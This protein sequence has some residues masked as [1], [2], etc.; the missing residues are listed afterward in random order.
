MPWSSGPE[1]AASPFAA[2][3][4]TGAG[5]PTPP[6]ARTAARCGRPMPISAPVSPSPWKRASVTWS[7]GESCRTGWTLP[8]TYAG[9]LPRCR[10][11]LPG[12]G[13]PLTPSGRPWGWRSQG[14]TPCSRACGS[15]CSTCSSPWAGTAVG[16]S[17]PRASRERATRAIISGIRRLTSC[18]CS[19][20]PGRSWPA[21]CWNTVIPSCR[22]PGSGPGCWATP[23]PCSPGGPST[24]RRSA[25]TTP[26]APL[27]SISTRTSPTLSGSI[28]PSPTI[29]ISWRSAVRSC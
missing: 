22:R 9:T 17:P 15:T 7:A 11:S 1:T 14:T 23:G 5:C 4:R 29:W 20:I 6:S 16:T 25:P 3:R 28:T 26:R 24:G 18:R 13:R 12:S 21:G 27:R 8:R 19:C 2:R 10:S